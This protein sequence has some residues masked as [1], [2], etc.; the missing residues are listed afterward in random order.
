MKE[1][2]QEYIV[3]RRQLFFFRRL[4]RI[5]TRP[6]RVQYGDGFIKPEHT[7]IDAPQPQH[8][9]KGADR[10]DGGSVRLK[11]SPHSGLL[12]RRRGV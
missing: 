4:D 8:G 12:D 1:A 7:L 5:H 3:E 2:P 6:F 9:G 11:L 10:H